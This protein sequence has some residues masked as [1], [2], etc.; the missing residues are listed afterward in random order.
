MTRT[1]RCLF[2]LAVSGLCLL[3]LLACI[4]AGW[5]WRRSDH[6]GQ[7]STSFLWAGDR[8]TVYSTEGRLT[9]IGPPPPAADPAVRRAAAEAAAGLRD[10]QF[11]WYAGF[12]LSE[13]VVLR[14]SPPSPDY[15]S[16]AGRFEIGM[17]YADKVRP[18]LAALEDPARFAAAHVLLLRRPYTGPGGEPFVRVSGEVSFVPSPDIP[19]L[20]GQWDMTVDTASWPTGK[21]AEAFARKYAAAVWGHADYEGLRV[22]LRLRTPKGAKAHTVGFGSNDEYHVWLVGEPDRAGLPAIRDGWHRELDVT[23]WSAP[24]WPFVAGTAVPPVLWS[25]VRLGRARIRR[26]RR[27]MGLCLRCGYDLRASEGRC[28]ECAEPVQGT[29]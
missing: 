20:H 2:R 24:F 22:T 6:G 9:L 15:E 26:R 10:D 25:G 19:E 21:Y 27:R 18:L 11:H 5:L 14:V 8:Y 1:L 28:P 7:D 13:N 17:A 4:G 23:Y 29:V 16:P 3:S 12:G